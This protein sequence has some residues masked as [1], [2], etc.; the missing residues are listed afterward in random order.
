[1]LLEL[2]DVVGSGVPL[3]GLAAMDREAAA[4]RLLALPVDSRVLQSARHEV[5]HYVRNTRFPAQAIEERHLPFDQCCFVRRTGRACV[6]DLFGLLN[7]FFPGPFAGPG[8]L[9]IFGHP[10]AGALVG[11][12]AARGEEVTI[13]L[14]GCF[15]AAAD[16]PAK[17]GGED[18]IHEAQSNLSCFRIYSHNIV[19]LARAFHWLTTILLFLIY[20]IHLFN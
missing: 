20:P 11:F 15:T 10:L 2:G 1:M 5:R 19:S 18:Q 9:L 14:F 13:L 8:E 17:S 6:G 4:L 3:D 7:S 16:D 12:A